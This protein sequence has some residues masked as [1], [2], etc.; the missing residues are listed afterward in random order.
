M[1]CERT[2]MSI[3]SKAQDFTSTDLAA[4]RQR[5]GTL[6]PKQITAWQ[7]MSPDQRL[8]LAFQAFQFALDAV[9]LTERQNHPELT[10][11]D[12]NWRIVSR[13]QGRQFAKR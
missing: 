1:D 8:G 5:L 4:L 10:E 6:D 9:R 2:L 12:L 11:D 3:P 7:N 13:M